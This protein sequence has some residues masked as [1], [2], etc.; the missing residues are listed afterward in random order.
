MRIWCAFRVNPS[1]SSPR[2]QVLSSTLHVR[3]TIPLNTQCH[4][5]QTRAGS[6]ASPGVKKS[7]RKKTTSGM[8]RVLAIAGDARGYLSDAEFEKEW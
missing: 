8:S 1:K 2:A 5:L 4:S 7:E 3:Q 6:V